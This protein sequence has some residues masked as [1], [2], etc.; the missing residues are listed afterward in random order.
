MSRTLAQLCTV[1][2]KPQ[3]LKQ[4]LDWNWSKPFRVFLRFC[5]LLLL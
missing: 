3:L 4:G 1:T 2:H 5:P